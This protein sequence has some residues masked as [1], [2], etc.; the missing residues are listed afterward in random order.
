MEIDVR[1]DLINNVYHVQVGLTDSASGKPL[2]PVEAE[3]FQRFGEP[4]V[5][6]GGTFTAGE[7]SF[8]LPADARRLP[9]QFPVKQA[10]SLDDYPD[11]AGDRATA[12]RNTMETRL[13]A[14]RDAALAETPGVTGHFVTAA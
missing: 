1:I 7:L 12:F 10:F 11:D 4:L 5:Q 3:A 6:I 13:I 2:T 9:S 8:T 14:A